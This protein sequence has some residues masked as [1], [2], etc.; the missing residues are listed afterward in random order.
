[1]KF[2]SAF[3]LFVTMFIVMVGFGII[4]PLMPFISINMGAS[5]FQ[6]G[7]L[8]ASYSLMQFI[9]SPIWGSLSD[10]Y[11]RKPIILIGL[12]GFAIT[13]FMFGLADKLWMLFAARIGGGILSSA[14]LPTAMAYVADVTDE[15]HRGAGM[16]MMGAAMG[17]GVIVGQAIGGLLANFHFGAP[18]FFA[19]GIAGLNL[20]FASVLLKE[21]RKPQTRKEIKYDRI[22]H[23]L[24][25]RGFMAYIFFIVFLVSFSISNFEAT[26]SLFSNYQLGFGAY[27]SGII[28]AFMGA[29]GV[30][31]QGFLIGRMIELMGE[32]RVI[33]AGLLLTGV[34]FLLTIVS[35]NL[36]FLIL[37]A[38]LA[39][40]GQS[41]CRPSLASLISKDTEYEEGATMGAM[42]SVDS[43]GRVLG[44]IFG[45]LLLQTH[46]NLP[47]I[48][49]GIVNLLAFLAALFV[50]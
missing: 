25:L 33:K 7:L 3:I 45:G 20:I 30:I 1:M 8:M 36:L 34:G 31:V 39:N 32:E 13:L 22:K 41:L 47:Y 38:A 2:Q 18:F 15:E 40:I 26:F 23:L 37:S 4:F 9:F 28:F 14:C 44:P 21:S 24:S 43:I 6:I 16:G 12:S 29:V 27:E 5:P 49:G 35:K 10:K 19:S 42:Q 50:I 17:L 11:G 48:G 46:I